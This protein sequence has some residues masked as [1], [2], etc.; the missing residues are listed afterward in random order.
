MSGYQRRTRPTTCR[1]AL[2]FLSL[3]LLLSAAGPDALRAMDAQIVERVEQLHQTD[4]LE[5]DG[6]PIA[7]VRAKEE[8]ALATDYRFYAIYFEAT[9]RCNLQCPMC[10]TGSN[11]VTRLTLR[12]SA[13][14]CRDCHAVSTTAPTSDSAITAAAVTPAR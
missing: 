4:R 10:M 7:A 13:R 11:E 14:V 5:V 2:Y 8:A 6:A 3:T 1:T 9:R 12:A